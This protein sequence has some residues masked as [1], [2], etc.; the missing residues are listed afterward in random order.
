MKAGHFGLALQF[1]FGHLGIQVLNK[2][3]HSL[4]KSFSVSRI[5]F[6]AEYKVAIIL[7]VASCHSAAIVMSVCG[8]VMSDTMVACKIVHFGETI[9]QFAITIVAP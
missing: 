5:A 4:L 9:V 6:A 3:M 7:P 2:N 1:G 8:I